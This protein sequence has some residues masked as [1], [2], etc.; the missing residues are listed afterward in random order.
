MTTAKCHACSV[1]KDDGDT[2]TVVGSPI[3]FL[4]H[5]WRDMDHQGFRGKLVDLI[6]GAAIQ[7][8]QVM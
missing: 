1:G 6:Q 4:L 3:R 7:T 8:T 2:V 5:C